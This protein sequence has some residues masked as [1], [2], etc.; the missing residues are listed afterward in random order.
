MSHC[1]VTQRD[2][3]SGQRQ[4]GFTM[5]TQHSSY[6]FEITGATDSIL[7]TFCFVLSSVI[8]QRDSHYECDSFHAPVRDTN[9]HFIPYEAIDVRNY[10]YCDTLQKS[11]CYFFLYFAFNA[12]DHPYNVF[13][14]K[15][16]TVYNRAKTGRQHADIKQI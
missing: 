9:L 1:C 4:L 2:S 12:L 11:F 6:N 3:L 15:N 13:Y 16:K 5:R 7:F 14:R 10:C 8:L